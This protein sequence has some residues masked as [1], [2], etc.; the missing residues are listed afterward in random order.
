MCLCLLFA[1]KSVRAGGKSLL[2]FFSWEVAAEDVS[3]SP[4][5]RCCSCLA[6]AVLMCPVV[7]LRCVI[8]RQDS[9]V[10][11]QVSL[12]THARNY[13]RWTYLHA[14]V[15][16]CLSKGVCAI[17]DHSDKSSVIS[18]Q[19]R[20]AAAARKSNFLSM[21]ICFTLLLFS[22]SHSADLSSFSQPPCILP[23]PLF[24]SRLSNLIPISFFPS[25][26]HLFCSPPSL[27]PQLGSTMR[28]RRQGCGVLCF[29]Y[30]MSH[31]SGSTVALSSFP[32]F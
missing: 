13:V 19:P 12:V 2:L 26:C 14:R 31:Y 15:C 22:K 25:S 9:T 29:V 17:M 30:V 4:E 16:V 8:R 27:T 28:R 32:S 6:W 21:L 10:I 3:L 5:R 18:A 20:I 1:C 7:C 23:A 11:Q 24:L